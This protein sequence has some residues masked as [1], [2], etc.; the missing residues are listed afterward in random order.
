MKAY[1]YK[2]S[3]TFNDVYYVGKTTMPDHRWH[4]HKLAA[5]RPNN[6]L[7]RSMFKHGI[8][9]FRFEIICECETEQEAYEIERK[10]IH[11]AKS[12]GIE[13]FNTAPGGTGGSDGEGLKKYFANQDNRKKLSVRV[14][15]AYQDPEVR[16]RVAK[17]LSESE[18]VEIRR[19]KHENPSLDYQTLADQFHVSGSTIWHIVNYKTWKN[20]K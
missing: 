16:K 20:V 7:Y 11:D 14:K 12:S 10:L 19:L 3:T 5:N 17:K 4:A 18:V 8:E 15:E 6:K 2:I 9:N 13:L 1:V